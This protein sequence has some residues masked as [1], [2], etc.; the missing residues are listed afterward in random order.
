MRSKPFEENITPGQHKA[1]TRYSG[2]ARCRYKRKEALRAAQTKAGNPPPTEASSNS[3]E[4]GEECGTTAIRRTKSD[5]TTPS[6]SD[7]HQGKRLKITDRESY[8]QVTKNLVRMTLVLESYPDKN[9]GADD[10]PPIRKL[11][12]IH[13]DRFIRK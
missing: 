2:T 6:P 12:R 13:S 11:L 10:L 9:I 4:R 3:D 1:R 8:A 5:F 7:S